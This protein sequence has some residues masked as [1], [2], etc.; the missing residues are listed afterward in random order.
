MASSNLKKNNKKKNTNRKVVNT[1]KSPAK[2]GTNITK[3]TSNNTKTNSKKT[4]SKNNIKNSSK[5]TYS[6]NN[7]TTKSKKADIKT[8]LE[9]VKKK[10]DNNKKVQSNKIQNKTI[11]KTIV[12]KNVKPDIKEYVNILFKEQQKKKKSHV[13]KLLFLILIILI[14]GIIATSNNKNNRVDKVL[15]NKCVEVITEKSKK[16]STL[17]T[18]KIAILTF[19]RITTEGTKKQ[20]FSDNEWVQSVDM[21]EKQ[22]KYLSKKGYNTLSL[23]EFNCWYE[24]ECKFDKKT[25]VLTFDDGDLSFYYLVSPILKKYHLKATMFVVGSRTKDKEEEKFRDTKR[26]FITK[27]NIEESK[28]K[29]PNIYYESHSYDF[30]DVYNKKKVCGMTSEELQEDFD[31]NKQFGFRYIAY[32][33]GNYNEAVVEKTEQNGYI[34]GFTFKHYDYA[35]RNSKRFEIPRFKINGES[36]ID[37]IEKIVNY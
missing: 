7:A 24:G 35:T 33:Y 36:D 4:Y 11:E 9:S 3:K 20:Y 28:I 37:T 6:K 22:M 29:Y 27:E 15:D 12:K 14:I 10:S 31:N 18:D 13:L 19:H 8:N 34:M 25:I 17:N 26:L 16:F 1:K 5:K 32:P 21:F 23:D 30:H 2:N